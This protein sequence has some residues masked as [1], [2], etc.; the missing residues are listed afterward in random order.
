MG[1]S[2]SGKTTFVNL[3]LRLYEPTSGEIRIENQNIR[4]ITQ[5]SLRNTIAIIPQDT[6][7]FHR[8]ILE[9]IRYGNLNATDEEVILAAK[10]ASAHDFITSLPHDYKSEVGEKGVKLSAGQRQRIL[11]A[12]ALLKNAPILIFDEATS[13]IDSIT[14]NYIQNNLNKIMDKKTA[15]VISHKLSTLM[16]MDRI[17]VFDSGKIVQDGP[18]HILLAQDGLFKELWE[19]QSHGILPT[20]LIQ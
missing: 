7:L 13:N 2:G 20:N 11:I 5:D 16:H 9:N 1:Y 4:N 14:E 15:I 3:I 8:S 6:S 17:L 19:A 10:K 12:R 18:P